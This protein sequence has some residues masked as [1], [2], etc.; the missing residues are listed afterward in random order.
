MGGDQLVDEFHYTAS[1]SSV[2]AEVNLRLNC[3]HGIG[4]SHRIFADFEE[5]M[6][7]FGVSDTDNLI[8]RQP[9]VVHGSFEAAA[10]VHARRQHHHRV[11]IEYDLQFEAQVANRL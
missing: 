11:A 4:Y 6:I 9:Q 5:R 3:R 8:G 10:L 1:I 7:V 2:R